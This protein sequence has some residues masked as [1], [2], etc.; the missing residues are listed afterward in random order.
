MAT[1]VIAT[2]LALDGEKEF[3]KQMGEVNSEL[4]TLKSEM[5]YTEAAFRGQ[6]N[7]VEALTEKDK[8]LRKEYE[9]Q[10]EKVRALEQAVKDASDAYGDSDKRVDAYKQSLFKAK[11]ELIDMEGELKDNEKYLDEARKSADKCADSIDE[12]GREVKEAADEVDDFDPQS[13]LDGLEGLKSTLTGGVIGAAA[14]GAVKET[15]GAVMELEES[16]REWRTAMGSLEVS[17]QAAGYTAEETAEAYDRLYGV[18]GDFQTTATTIANLQAIGMEQ[19]D[20][21]TIIDACTGAWSK[22]GDSIPIDGLAESINETIRSGQVTGTFA[23]ILNWGTE[24]LETFGVTLKEDTEANKEWNEAVQDAATSEDYFNL[25]LS[26][27]TSQAERNQLMMK[28]LQEQG[29]VPLGEE[30]REVNADVV[31]ANESQAAMEE[32]MGHLGEACAPLANALRNTAATAVEFLAD[33]IDKTIE[34][35]RELKKEWEEDGMSTSVANWSQ[36][37]VQKV[38]VSKINGS[39]ADGLD[40]VPFDGYRAELHYG[41]RVM[42]AAENAALATLDRAVAALSS[43]P[44]QKVSGSDTPQTVKVTV[45]VVLNG[46]A[47]GEAVT[48]FQLNEGRANG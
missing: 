10:A 19:E 1:R 22:Y 47:V 32:A 27:C 15:I 9:Q 25:A 46:R 37:A 13:L 38:D 26:E 45:P 4:K 35:V 28:F 29:L 39:H 41:E 20:L 8:I 12:F 21:M 23:D 43:Q 5:A 3:K 7:S 2:R 18:L 36:Y 40:F 6:A 11:K 34:K 31:A 30:W 17:S 48:T 44:Q 33:T 16:T 14:I 24:E 42:T